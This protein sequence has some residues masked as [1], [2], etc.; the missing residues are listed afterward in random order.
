MRE[1]NEKL[2]GVISRYIV[3][4]LQPTIS[5]TLGLIRL[6]NPKKKDFEQMKLLQNGTK[7]E[8]EKKKQNT[9]RVILFPTETQ[10]EPVRVISYEICYGCPAV[11]TEVLARTVDEAI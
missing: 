10:A 6:R 1:D 4:F 2:L 5:A 8:T 7:T 9:N 11:T 3:Q